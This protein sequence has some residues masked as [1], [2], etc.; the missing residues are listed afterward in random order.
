VFKKVSIG[1]IALIAIT[2]LGLRLFGFNS[3]V[4]GSDSMYPA[5]P[6]NSVVYVR[7]V[8]PVSL[9]VGD[10][11]AFESNSDLP[12]MHRIIEIKADEIIT[13][14]DANDNQDAPISFNEII[15][16]VSFHIPFIGFLFYN[17]SFWLIVVCFVLL[18]YLIMIFSKEMK[19]VRSN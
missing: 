4:V 1:V 3:Y 12:L 19:K 8:E 16:K 15:G 2:L 14:G 6:K 9:E 17:V 7:R 11:I 13:K 10:I 18:Y 5:I